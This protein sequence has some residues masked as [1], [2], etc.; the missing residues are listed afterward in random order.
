[1]NGI[2]GY[3]TND[4]LICWGNGHSLHRNPDCEN[5]PGVNP[6]HLGCCYPPP[7]PPPEDDEEEEDP[8]PQPPAEGKGCITR[9]GF[10]GFCN[11]DFQGCRDQG[12]QLAGS[13]DC[14]NHPVVGG[15]GG[16][17]PKLL[18]CY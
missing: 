14:G 16:G 1:M 7:P 10:Y 18:C 17:Q 3:C 5:F 2:Q 12:D 6:D 11:M 8:L 9:N 4:F 15:G 13:P